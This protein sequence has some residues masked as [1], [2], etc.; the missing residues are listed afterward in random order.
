MVN[1]RLF[2][3]DRRI[4]LGKNSR[5]QV[6]ES[7]KD[8]AYAERVDGAKTCKRTFVTKS[9]DCDFLL[10]F[11]LHS[12]LFLEGCRESSLK[13]SRHISRSSITSIISL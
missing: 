6:F 3:I 1:F 8:R 9:F 13:L 12:P 10:S 5:S 11:L 4:T 7:E 2:V